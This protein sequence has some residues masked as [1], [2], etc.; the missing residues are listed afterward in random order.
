MKPRRDDKET[1]KIGLTPKEKP[2]KRQKPVQNAVFQQKQP[3]NREKYV[4]QHKKQ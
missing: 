4:E 2:R 1:F 3:S